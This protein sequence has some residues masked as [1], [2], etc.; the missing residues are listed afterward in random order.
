M[1]YNN[2]METKKTPTRLYYANTWFTMPF[3]VHGY[4]VEDAT[5][6]NVAEAARRELAEAIKQTLNAMEP[7]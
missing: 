4:W 1:M 3:R 2:Y 5:G 6:K 7:K